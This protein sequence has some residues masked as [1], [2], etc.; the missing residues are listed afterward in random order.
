MLKSLYLG[1][2]TST[3]FFS[4][5]TPPSTRMKSEGYSQSWAATHPPLSMVS[6]IFSRSPPFT[7]LGQVTVQF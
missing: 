5:A 1:S 2:L 4:K 6:P 3:S 7:P